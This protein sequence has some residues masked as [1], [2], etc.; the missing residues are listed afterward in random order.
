MNEPQKN[1]EKRLRAAV[2][3][4]LDR[5]SVMRASTGWQ[6]N[7]HHKS[8]S[9]SEGWTVRVEPGPVSALVE[10]LESFERVHGGAHVLPSESVTP[11]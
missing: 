11:A 9:V 5:F 3:C 1:I 6:A 8:A 10:A 2:R 7:L 4:G